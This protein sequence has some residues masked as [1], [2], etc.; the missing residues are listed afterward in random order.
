MDVPLPCHSGAPAIAPRALPARLCACLLL[1]MLLA[2]A[3]TASTAAGAT[4]DAAAARMRELFPPPPL[5]V[6]EADFGTEEL[7]PSIDL[8]LGQAGN[9]CYGCLRPG[10]EIWYLSARHAGQPCDVGGIAPL[11]VWRHDPVADAPLESTLEDFFAADDPEAITIFYV[12]GSRVTEEGAFE[13]TPEVYRK[14]VCGAADHERVRLV[15]FSWPNPQTKH[16]ASDFRVA[17]A[18]ADQYGRIFGRVLTAIDPRVKIGVCTFSLGAQIACAALQELVKIDAAA[19]RPVRQVRAV[20][21]SAAVDNTFLLPGRRYDRALD[22]V[23]RMLLVTNRRDLV[24]KR[25]YLMNCERPQALGYA[26]LTGIGLLGPRGG[27]ISEFDATF[28]LGVSH[29]YAR[30]L[31]SPDVVALTRAYVLWRGVDARIDGRAEP[32]IACPRLP[33]PTNNEELA[34]GPRSDA[35]YRRRHGT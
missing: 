33:E 5:P 2:S 31:Q 28:A 27:K 17:E 9:L 30:H 14:F 3:T 1:A 13:R 4:S 6:V 24:N 12:H 19:N 10:D 23:D 29:G 26:G 7:E 8:E 34:D 22:A 16:V 25:F 11:R 18:G 15:L 32:V 20:F 21:W 35:D